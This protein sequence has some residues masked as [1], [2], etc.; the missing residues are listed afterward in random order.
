MLNEKAIELLCR[1]IE[2]PRISR[3]EKAAADLL[4]DYMQG[5]LGLEVKRKGNNRTLMQSGLPCS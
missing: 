1:L 5:E 4:K 3:E 2:V